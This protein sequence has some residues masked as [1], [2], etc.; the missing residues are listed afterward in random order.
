MLARFSSQDDELPQLHTLELTSERNSWWPKPKQL[1]TLSIALGSW[2]IKALNFDLTHLKKIT[3]GNCSLKECLDVLRVAP[4]LTTCTLIQCY[5]H[6]KED[7]DLQLPPQPIAYPNIQTFQID[8]YAPDTLDCISSFFLFPSLKTLS[9]TYS[10]KAVRVDASSIVRLLKEFQC[11]L[12]T[13]TL[14]FDRVELPSEGFAPLFL[15]LPGLRHLQ[16]YFSRDNHMP[17]NAILSLL[18]EFSEAN[19]DGI[20]QPRY[21]PSLHSLKF[22]TTKFRDWSKLPDMFGAYTANDHTFIQH[23]CALK[24][25]MISSRSDYPPRVSKKNPDPSSV[26][27]IDEETLKRILWLGDYGGVK[28][29]L[30]GERIKD[31]IIGLG[32]KWYGIGGS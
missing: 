31:D 5:K 8:L 28:W 10:R 24:N 14:T 15:E 7:I 29:C 16:L 2:C 25:V 11:P 18:S 23:R 32:K 3:L 19:V 21:L 27:P 22:T 4:L 26:Y 6:D 1:E 17:S 13:L 12:G 20:K 9:L 30:Q